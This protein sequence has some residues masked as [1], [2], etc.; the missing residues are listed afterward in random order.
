MTDFLI[1][2]SAPPWPP[3][4]RFWFFI[5][6]ASLA[7]FARQGRFYIH[8]TRTYRKMVD[9]LCR[10]RGSNILNK[11]RVLQNEPKEP[12]LTPLSATPDAAKISTEPTEPKAPKLPKE[13]HRGIRPLLEKQEPSRVY[14]AIPPKIPTLGDDLQPSWLL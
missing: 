9:E 11:I 5:F 13:D 12:N 4:R 7:S 3:R 8:L 10:L 1:T 6:L 2:V 14:S